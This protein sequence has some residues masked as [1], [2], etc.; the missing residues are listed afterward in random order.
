MADAMM[1]QPSKDDLVKVVDRVREL[2]RSHP[3]GY[4]MPVEVIYPGGDFG[5]LHEYL[6]EFSRV[7][8]REQVN[9]EFP[10]APVI[11]MSPEVEADLLTKIYERTPA[12]D[13][14]LYVDD[15]Y[16]KVILLRPGEPLKLFVT[17]DLWEAD[18]RRQQPSADDLIQSKN[19]REKKN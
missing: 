17:Q 4:A 10:S 16:P 5:P 19:N 18:A 1:S 15:L 2:S 7:S 3:A 13:R 9:F 11:I 8:W 12:E 14:R 6:R